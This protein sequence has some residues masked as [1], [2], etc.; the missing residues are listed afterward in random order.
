MEW[1]SR[2]RSL[3]PR[4][5]PGPRRK[6]SPA[7]QQDTMDRQ[8]SSIA[9]I[10]RV[11]K[12]RKT[13]NAYSASMEWGNLEKATYRRP[14]PQTGLSQ[15]RMRRETSC[16]SVSLVCKHHQGMQ[17]RRSPSLA[18]YTHTRTYGPCTNPPPNTRV[19]PTNAR[20]LLYS[21]ARR[22]RGGGGK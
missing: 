4:P 6:I 19:C 9:A 12:C 1:W 7:E 3:I 20:P 14:P 10:Q 21:R 8:T 17:P 2:S 15:A 18:L 13:V 5:Q 16:F 11:D 22:D